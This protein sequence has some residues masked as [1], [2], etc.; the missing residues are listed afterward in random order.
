[1]LGKIE[2]KGQYE[3]AMPEGLDLPF[4]VNRG[5]NR[6]VQV[7][8]AST[9]VVLGQVVLASGRRGSFRSFLQCDDSGCCAALAYRTC[10]EPTSLLDPMA[11]MCFVN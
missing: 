6:C 7:H 4:R 3:R 8:L 1:M 9:L 11:F 10:S 2:R 5:R